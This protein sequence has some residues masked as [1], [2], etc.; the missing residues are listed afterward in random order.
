MRFPTFSSLLSI[1]DLAALRKG[2]GPLV[3]FTIVVETSGK[4]QL[5]RFV[6]ERLEDGVKKAKASITASQSLSMYAIAWDGLVTLERREWDAVLVEAGDAAEDLGV[7]F[8]QR[9][10]SGK[11]RF[12]R[13]GHCERVGNP[14]LIGRPPSR[15]RAVGV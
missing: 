11:R 10:V 14:A 5:N 15:L 8:S 2:G 12:F 9:Y 1:T 3:P 13:Q 7:L 6:T 4:K